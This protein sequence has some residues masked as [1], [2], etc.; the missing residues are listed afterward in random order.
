MT[1]DIANILKGYIE[2]LPFIDKIGGLVKA[3]TFMDAPDEGTAIKRI[4]PVDCGT[5]AKECLSGKYIP[6]LPDSRFMS[7]LFFED[8]G[9]VLLA[10][11]QKDFSFQSNMILVG[12]LNKKKL[13]KTSCSI[14]ALAIA[15]ILDKFPTNYFNSSPYTRILIQ[16]EGELPK[17]NA[18][19]SKYTMDEE[20]LQ[21]LMHPYDYFALSIN[22]KFTIPKA[23]LTLLTPGPENCDE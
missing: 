13:G 21:F 6:L 10:R 22:V 16:V 8:Q 2:T 5:S 1:S 14:S 18:I 23:C 20:K 4:M 19:F 9:T 7:V 12:W 3:V 15:S 11:D 17:T